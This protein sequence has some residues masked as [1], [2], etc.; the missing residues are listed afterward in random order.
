MNT[1]ACVVSGHA[2]VCN[3]LSSQ[4][5][6]KSECSFSLSTDDGGQVQRTVEEKLSAEPHAHEQPAAARHSQD[7]SCTTEATIMQTSTTSCLSWGYISPHAWV[8]LL[9]AISNRNASLDTLVVQLL[10]AL[11]QQQKSSEILPG[12]TILAGKSSAGTQVCF[13]GETIRF[14]S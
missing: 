11:L 10:A 1:E 5:M 4:K 12:V 8:G 3:V 14:W 9:A 2:G 6:A 7:S 13:S